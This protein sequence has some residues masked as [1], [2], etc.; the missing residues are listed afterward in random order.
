MWVVDN[1]NTW[2]WTYDTFTKSKI[3]GKER[4]FNIESP[5][6][7]TTQC[8]KQCHY[9]VTIDYNCSYACY[10]IAMLSAIYFCLMNER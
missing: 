2:I 1:A 8:S 4:Q 6:A 9:T 3:D 7:V 5:Y 10:R